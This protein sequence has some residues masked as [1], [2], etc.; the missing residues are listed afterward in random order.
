M[1]TKWTKPVFKPDSQEKWKGRLMVGPTLSRAW[2]RGPLVVPSNL[3]EPCECGRRD[4][5]KMHKYA[6]AMDN[7]AQILASQ[8]EKEGEASWFRK[9]PLDFP[10]DRVLLGSL[11]WAASVSGD[12]HKRSTN[13]WKCRRPSKC[14]TSTPCL[15]RRAR[16]LWGTWKSPVIVQGELR[17]SHAKLMMISDN[18]WVLLENCS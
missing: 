11:G 12:K 4:G 10:G 8:K 17:H 18:F 2:I 7:P 16:K 3:P 9:E 5:V 14:W 13:M 6:F 15:E 1:Q